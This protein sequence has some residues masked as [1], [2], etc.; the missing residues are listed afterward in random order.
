MLRTLCFLALTLT[1]ALAIVS[2]ATTLLYLRI[3]QPTRRRE[4]LK[5]KIDEAT[6]IRS[7]PPHRETSISDNILAVSKPIRGVLGLAVPHTRR[8]HGNRL[9][10]CSSP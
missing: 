9:Q 6:M 8:E 3:L 7:V 4:P 2:L 5:S 10:T 1:T